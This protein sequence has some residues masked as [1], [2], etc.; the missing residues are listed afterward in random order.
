MLL[1]VMRD[2]SLA[3]RNLRRRPGFALVAILTLGVGVGATTAVFTAVNAVLLAPLPYAEPDRLVMLR[4]RKLPQFPSFSVAPGNFLAWKEQAR[5]FERLAAFRSGSYVMAGTAEPERVEGARVTA[6]LFP[7]LGVPPA[8]GRWF[9]EDEDQP[10]A[11][12]PIMLSHQFWR[13]RFGGDPAVVGR[14]IVLENQPHTIVGVMPPPF[15]FPSERVQMWVPMAFTSKDSERRSSHYLGAI[16]RLRAGVPLASASADLQTVASRLAATHPESNRGWEVVA[17]PLQEYIARD[18][19]TWLLFLLGAVTLVLFIA[20]VNIANLLVARG[21]GRRKELATRAAL[22]ATRAR[23]VRQ[24]SAENLVIAVP[25]CACGLLMASALSSVFLTLAPT[26]L[27]FAAGSVRLDYRVLFFSLGLMAL[28]PVVFG[29]APSLQASRIA[30]H[31]ALA[32]GGRTGASVGRRGMGGGLVVLEIGLALFLTVGAGLL[33]RSFHLL[34]QVSP[35]FAPSNALVAQIDL[36][37][38]TYPTIREHAAFQSALLEQVASAPGIQAVGLASGFPL[39]DDWVLSLTIEG[40]EPANTTHGSDLPQANGY[41]VS[42]GYFAAM[43]IP[44]RRGRP[45]TERDTLGALRVAIINETLGRRYF[46]GEDPIGKRVMISSESSEEWRE[47]VGIVG[48]VKQYGLAEETT[49]QIYEALQQVPFS[50]LKSFVSLVVRTPGDPLGAVP[51]VRRALRQIDAGLP[52][53]RVATLEALLDESMG[54]RRLSTW[55]LGVFGATAL[56]LAAIGL[57]G[58]L[59]HLVGQRTYEIGVRIA[60]GARRVDILGLVMGRGL[61]LTGAGIVCG[62]VGAVAFRRVMASFLFG[63]TTTDVATYALAVVVLV[64][65]A[66]LAMAVPALRATRVD[67]IVALRAE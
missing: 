25:G 10:G 14:S 36:P 22:G 43:G 27:P 32:H 55:L 23:L 33:V 31:S 39:R 67:P 61:A 64:T 1:D 52:L 57:Y 53:A 54:S 42:P 16:G 66:L 40:R 51:T 29:L 34:Q 13:D 5:A 11:A 7:L 17:T 47:I 9:R 6:D 49:P 3:L 2:V 28:T 20:C 8:L 48:D 63:I 45:F 38:A 30:L 24:L 59:S 62:L 18:V 37:K 50:T 26:A 19:R 44:F 60:H 4:E 15:V 46:P 58:V 41:R 56:L 21:S 65:A 12:A 35:G